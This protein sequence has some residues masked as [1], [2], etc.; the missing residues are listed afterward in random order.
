MA[1]DYS[2]TEE[3]INYFSTLEEDLKEYGYD[4]VFE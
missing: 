4:Q 2:T 1:E 3:W